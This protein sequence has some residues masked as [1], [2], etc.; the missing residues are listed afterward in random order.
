M[1]KRAS[2]REAVRWIALNDNSGSNDTVLEVR[3]YVST[4]FVAD[5]FSKDENEVAEAIIRERNREQL[6]AQKASSDPG[7]LERM[8]ME[9][10]Q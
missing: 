8:A 3:G 7:R 2:Y 9:I 10:E 1:S 6:R 5:L 4:L